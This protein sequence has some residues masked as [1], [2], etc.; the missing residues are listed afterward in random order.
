[1]KRGWMGFWLSV[2]GISLTAAIVAPPCWPQSGN[3]LRHN[4]ELR[5]AGLLPGRTAIAKAEILLGKASKRDSYQSAIWKKCDGQELIVDLDSKGIVQ[6]I[7]A[8]KDSGE[9]SNLDCSRSESGVSKW[10]T[11]AGLQI[12]HT[13]SRVLQLY[14][15]PDSRS[16]STKDGQ[17]LELLY[18]AFDWAGPDVPQV[19][20]VLCTVEQDGKP[21]RVVE[22]TLAA[23]SL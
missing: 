3:A 5:L 17:R 12:G 13:T 2:R 18:Y 21:G 1:M 6:Q 20:E 16:P 23:S 22:I 10:A 7:R 15:Q 14:G 8:M 9:Q 19:M 11:G 4:N